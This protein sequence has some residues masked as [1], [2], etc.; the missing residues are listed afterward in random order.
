M[1]IL[2][3]SDLVRP[4][5]LERLKH[6]GFSVECHSN[7]V[8]LSYQ[9]LLEQ[10]ADFDAVLC[11]IGDT[12]DRAVLDRAVHAKIFANF[13]AGFNHID[14]QYARS[15]GIF[16]TNTPDVLTDATADTTMLLLLAVARRFRMAERLMRDGKSFVGW[17][18]LRELGIDLRGKTIGIVGFGR[19]GRAVAIRAK[20]FGM[21]VIFSARSQHQTDL[22]IQVGFDELLCK[23]DVISIHTPLT[24]QTKHL[25]TLREFERMK[26]HAILI[27]TARGAIVKESDLVIAL[28]QGKF[29][30]VGLDVYEF[31][32]E[33]TAELFE[34]ERVVMLPH[35]GAATI[36]AREAMS[37]LC[38]DNIIAAFEGR[39]PPN[40]VWQVSSA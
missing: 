15:K 14:W 19:I 1:K 21:T 13:G 30:G 3:T 24:E 6:Y 9:A 2:V 20:S 16:V 34:H 28:R 38:A 8:P 29:F 37:N 18:T 35:I 23:S 40:L 4:S 32:P 17:A 11:S 36:D 39:M 27:N 10:V 31:E 5:A 7:P 12:I 25:F 33:V 22:G 26:S